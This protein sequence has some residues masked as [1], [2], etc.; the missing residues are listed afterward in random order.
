MNHIISLYAD[1]ALIYVTKPAESIEL[2]MSVM[3]EFGQ[4][5]GLQVN[6]KKK[7]V[8]FPM[9]NTV[10]QLDT[11]PI[12]E[13]LKWEK[14]H[15]MQITHDPEEQYQLN[16]GR[17]ITGLRNSTQFW[18]KLPLSVMGRVA[19]SKMVLLPRCLYVLQNSMQNWE[20]HICRTE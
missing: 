13:G 1:D 4:S 7:S 17:V 10:K 18:N 15:W 19:L 20:A 3:K 9:G 5:S 6:G 14:H 12:E 11:L 16:M 8:V 2:L